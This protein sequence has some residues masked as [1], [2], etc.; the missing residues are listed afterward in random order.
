MEYVCEL[1]KELETS[2]LLW[3]FCALVVPDLLLIP[4]PTR[5]ESSQWFTTLTKDYERCCATTWA[6]P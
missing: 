4:D 2:S 1:Y 5:L 6:L 3:T